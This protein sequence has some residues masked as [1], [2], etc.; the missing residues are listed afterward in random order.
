MGNKLAA[1]VT[2]AFPEAYRAVMP[3]T[4]RFEGAAVR[5]QY[6]GIVYTA[7]DYSQAAPGI[8][9]GDQCPNFTAVLF[10][11][12][13]EIPGRSGR[14]RIYVGCVA[15]DV[16]DGSGL[17]SGTLDLFAALENVF[18]A[19]LETTDGSWTPAVFSPKSGALHLV[20]AVVAQK[21]LVTQ[22]RRKFRPPL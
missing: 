4:A 6:N 11:K 3:T 14:G 18:R 17:A 5:V 15:E 9:V 16:T 7:E 8:R 2:S 12:Y 22:R 21:P 20:S 19:T 10:K 1:A 13:T